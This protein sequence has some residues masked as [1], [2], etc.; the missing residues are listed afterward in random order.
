MLT[1]WHKFLLSTYYSKIDLA[2]LVIHHHQTISNFAA[3]LF[4]Y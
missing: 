4:M 2:V 3:Q 1:Q